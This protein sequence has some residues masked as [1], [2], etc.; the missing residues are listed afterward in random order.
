MRETKL[1]PISEG[2][3]M[4]EV[5]QSDLLAG[6][7]ENGGAQ[8]GLCRMGFAFRALSACS[9]CRASCNRA[10]LWDLLPS[11]CCW[12]RPGGIQWTQIRREMGF[13]SPESEALPSNM[14]KLKAALQTGTEGFS[15][16][17]DKFLF[18]YWCSVS[19]HGGKPFGLAFN[20]F[21]WDFLPF[22]QLCIC[23][24]QSKLTSDENGRFT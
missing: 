23:G 9:S 13:L 2:L 15:H 7:P 14:T 17:A 5:P 16:V 18:C 21:T 22:H 11:G 1:H 4:H 3:E 20:L 6:E 24:L 8:G 12:G 19:L 10:R